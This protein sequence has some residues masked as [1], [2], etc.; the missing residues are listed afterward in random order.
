MRLLLSPGLASVSGTWN[1]QAP[2]PG[3][4]IIPPAAL[5]EMVGTVEPEEG[6]K[7]LGVTAETCGQPGAITKTRE[8]EKEKEGLCSTGGLPKQRDLLWLESPVC[9]GQEDAPHWKNSSAVAPHAQGRREATA[10]NNSVKKKNSIVNMQRREAA[11]CLSCKRLEVHHQEGRSYG[12]FQMPGIST[13]SQI[14][15]DMN[16]G[17]SAGA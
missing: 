11:S 3:R 4:R 10:V 16:N 17:L 9:T 6:A 15:A 14:P 8:S 1:G 13:F 2:K 12:L 7:S 5:G